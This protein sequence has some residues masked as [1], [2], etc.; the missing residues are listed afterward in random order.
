MS[1]YMRILKMIEAGE[2]SPEEGAELLHN[3][4]SRKENEPENEITT[5]GVLE[6]IES[7]ELTADEGIDLMGKS[8]NSA[9]TISENKPYQEEETHQHPPF[10]SDDEMERWK[11]WW[12]IPLYVGVG[13]VILSTFW[14]NAA[15]QNSQFSFWFF[16]SWIPLLIGLLVISLA[17]GSRSGP[18]IHVRVRGPKERVAISIPAPMG[19]TSW[20]LRTFGH[21]IPHLEKTSIDEILIALEQTSEQNTPLYVQVDEGE[22]GEH[23]EVFI[24]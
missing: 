7:G 24:G 6:K 11:K 9:Q 4:G 5:L 8:G 18:W 15:Y 16:C 21:Y 20:A 19:I 22:D 23:V 10:I 12:T 13:I 2:I 1:E 14:L 3:I 17:W